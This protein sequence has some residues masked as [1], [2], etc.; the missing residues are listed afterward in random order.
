MST[1]LRTRTCAARTRLMTCLVVS[2]PLL[3]GVAP[4]SAQA[5]CTRFAS[6]SGSDSS[7]GSVKRPYRTAQKLVDSLSGGQA[8]CLRAGTYVGNVTFTR[9]GAADAPITVT[10]YPGEQATIS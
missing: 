4:A 6:T 10:S 1:P 7:S 8:G 9:S 2:L 5:A 3:L